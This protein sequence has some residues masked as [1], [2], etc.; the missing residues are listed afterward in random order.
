M[1]YVY[2]VSRF[3]FKERTNKIVEKLRLVSEKFNRD[4]EIVINETLDDVY[5]LKERFKYSE[6]IITAIGGDGSINLVLNDLMG[7]NNI[8][9]YIPYGTG[10]DFYRANLEDLKS[11][12]H[13]IDVIRIND[14][15]FINVSCFGIDADIAN[16]DRYV[17]NKLIPESMRYNA[18]VIHHFLTYKG[19]KMRVEFDD[20]TI[21]QDFTTI[22]VANAKYYGGGY[23]VSP[24][25]KYDDGVFDVFLV[26]RLNKVKMASII[27]SM[28]NAG[29]LKNPALKS[30][31]TNKLVISADETFKANIDGEAI[32]ANRFE[33][34]MIPSG[35]KI[36]FDPEFI[37]EFLK[38]K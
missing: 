5:K 33:L 16:D 21:E 28:K 38:N 8:L 15:Y 1:K 24:N 35:F 37:S 13:D 31:T 22:I 17:H 7:T 2:I 34:E 29:H 9:S 3:N 10:N 19:R 20:K 36:D 25:S 32:E 26:D 23:K 12:I 18:G 27:L 30:F 14:R 6:D 11:G 4:Y